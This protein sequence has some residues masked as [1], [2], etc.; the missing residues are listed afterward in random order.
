MEFW[1]GEWQPYHLWE[2]S[3]AE[4]WCVKISIANWVYCWLN[5]ALVIYLYFNFFFRICPQYSSKSYLWRTCS[6]FS[7]TFVVVRMNITCSFWGRVNWN[8]IFVGVQLVCFSCSR[9]FCLWPLAECMRSGA[10]VIMNIPRVGLSIS[11][12]HF[13]AAL[14]H[15]ELDSA[16][17]LFANTTRAVSVFSVAL[18]RSH[19][20]C[21][22][23]VSSVDQFKELGL[24]LDYAG[25]QLIGQTRVYWRNLDY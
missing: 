21:F 7:A 12:L 2:S 24:L 14:F 1:R 10:R 20:R 17:S 25:R 4:S 11:C 16:P 6:L 8:L 13:D 15:R 22:R 3:A 19:S 23:L 9:T 5:C 18:R